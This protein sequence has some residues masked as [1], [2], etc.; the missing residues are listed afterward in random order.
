MIKEG[1]KY[2]YFHKGEYK[3]AT[4][5]EVTE[6]KVLLSNGDVLDMMTFEEG[7][8][9]LS[10]GSGDGDINDISVNIE[11]DESG[12][13]ILPGVTKPS[14]PASHGDIPSHPM[15]SHDQPDSNKGKG[16]QAKKKVA[17]SSPLAALIEK[18]KKEKVSITITV[19]VELINKGLYDMLQESYPDEFDEVFVQSVINN[20]NAQEGNVIEEAFKESIKNSYQ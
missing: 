5:H 1:E 20:V 3:E 19:D 9:R 14:N 12:I 4:V 17:I 11:T 7:A 6:E 13:P 2:Q 18:A 16:V 15:V 10:S 8:T